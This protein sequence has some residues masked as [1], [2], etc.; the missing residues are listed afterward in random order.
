MITATETRESREVG[1]RETDG[2]ERAVDIAIFYVVACVFMGISTMLSGIQWSEADG[3]QEY[4]RLVFMHKPFIIL[5]MVVIFVLS[6]V[7]MQIG[8][9]HFHL[10]YY[11]ISIIWLA[12]SWVAIVTLW[13]VK[14]IRPCWTELI[15]IVLCHLGLGIS[16][17]AS[18]TR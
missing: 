18:M 3:V 13:L 12:T 7:M 10:S 6:G 5:V 2:R 17:L 9:H 16:T 14:G 4:L 15:G 8:K 11:K 1:A